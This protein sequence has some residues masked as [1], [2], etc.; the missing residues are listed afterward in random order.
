[1]TTR[2]ALPLYLN[3]TFMRIAWRRTIRPEDFQMETEIIGTNKRFNTLT[4]RIARLAVE[5]RE[6]DAE[7]AERSS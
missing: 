6:T 1:M 4:R 2:N 5:A 3:A 7:A